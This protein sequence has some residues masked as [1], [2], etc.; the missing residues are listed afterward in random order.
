MII[1]GSMTGL[2][3]GRLFMAGLI[4]G[5]LIGVSLMTLT[6]YYARR[7]GYEGEARATWARPRERP[8]RQC[9]L[10]PCRL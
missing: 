9:L 10:W 7:D 6:Y 1:Y 3:V 5:I 2:S 8:G 4:P